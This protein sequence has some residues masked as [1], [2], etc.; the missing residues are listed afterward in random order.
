MISLVYDF[1]RMDALVNTVLQYVESPVALNKVLGNR[2]EE[3]L[4]EYF[5]TR[6]SEPNKRGWRKTGWWSG[7]AK[8]TA[9]TKV[10]ERGATVTIAHSEGFATRLQGGSIRPKEARALTI[11]AVEEA[12]GRSVAEYEAATGRKLFRPAGARYLAYSKNESLTVVY[13]L[14]RQVSIT[15]DPNALPPIDDLVNSLTQESEDYFKRELSNQ[16]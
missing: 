5:F 3:E 9:L 16:L 4:Q 13:F 7:V 6:N 1:T 11:P 10:D 14:A 2:L 12:Y 8:D 15:A